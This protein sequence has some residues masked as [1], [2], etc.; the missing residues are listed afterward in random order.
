[1]DCMADKIVDIEAIDLEIERDVQRYQQEYNVSDADIAW[2]LLRLGT[3]YYFK[4][5]ASR[6]MNGNQAIRTGYM[7]KF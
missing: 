2:M 4:D 6:G 1:M 7:D 3:C 5:I